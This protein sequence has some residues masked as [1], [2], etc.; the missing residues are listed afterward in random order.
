MHGRRWLVQTNRQ[1]KTFLFALA[2]MA[3]A[4]P[5]VP[6]LGYLG[7]PE[8]ERPAFFATAT[9]A[10]AVE[11]CRELRGRLWFWV[12]MTAIAACHVL[13]VML[14]P[15]RP[16]WVPAP[17]ILLLCVVDFALILAIV[18]FIEKRRVRAAGQSG[19][20]MGTTQKE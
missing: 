17:F 14:L 16:G 11:V 7:R 3:V 4:A 19:S 8:L 10:V 5:L 9:I 12:T 13:L 6:L 18:G 15:W 20:P 1:L 2:A